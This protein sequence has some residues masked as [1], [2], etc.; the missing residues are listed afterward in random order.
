M[1]SKFQVCFF[2]IIFKNFFSFFENSYEFKFFLRRD[3]NYGKE[4]VRKISLVLKF[5]KKKTKRLSNGLPDNLRFF[6][7]KN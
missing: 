2:N 7:K 5:K 4:T 3:E 1:L 6:F